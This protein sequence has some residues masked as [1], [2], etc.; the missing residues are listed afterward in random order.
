MTR[1]L[2][3][4]CLCGAVTVTLRGEPAARANCHCATCRDF[5]GTPM[6]SATA[7][8]PEQVTIDGGHATFPH[9]SKSMARTWCAAC[10]EIVFGTSRL[11]MRVVPNSLTAR[12]HGGPLP[13]DLQ[14][15]M[16]LFYR[17]RVLDVVDA[18]PK[19]VDGWDGP[20]LDPAN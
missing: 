5:Y 2:S 13:G 4:R 19:Y 3:A 9:P 6:L 8:P 17:Q 20:T 14:P 12:A 15:T 7:W 11:G 10:G 1:T 18:L 16:H